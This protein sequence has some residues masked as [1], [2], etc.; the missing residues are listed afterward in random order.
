MLTVFDDSL[1]VSGV[2]DLRSQRSRRSGY[3]RNYNDNQS[4]FNIDLY[5][6]IIEEEEDENDVEDE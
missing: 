3:S 6:N 4:Q 5:Q 1:S 2:S